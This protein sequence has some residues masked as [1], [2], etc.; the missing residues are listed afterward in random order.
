MWETNEEPSLEFPENSVDTDARDDELVI[1]DT[2]STVA[3]IARQKGPEATVTDSKTKSS[4]SI[5]PMVVPKSPRRSNR[6][7]KQTQFFVSA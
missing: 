1:L 3:D 4:E 2:K 5:S 7:R 6:V